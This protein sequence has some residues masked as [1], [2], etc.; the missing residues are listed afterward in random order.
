MVLK[1]RDLTKNIKTMTIRNFYRIA[2]L[3]IVSLFTGCNEWDE[4]NRTK[5]EELN[6]TLLEAISKQP[7]LSKF[8]EYLATTGYDV[9]LASSKTFTVWAPNNDALATLSSDITDDDQKLAQFIG[10]HISYQEYFKTSAP[11]RIKMVNGKNLTWY[12]TSL[13]DAAI[14]TA[15]HISRN[16]V[17][18][19]I[20]GI[21]PVKQN[22]WEV[23]NSIEAGQKQLSFLN[24]LTYDLF[25][26]S[27]AT[28]T[29]VDPATGLPIYEAGT[30]YVTKNYFF[31]GIYD[32]TNE[33]SLQTFFVLTDEAFDAELAKLAPF[34]KNVS[35]DQ[36]STDSLS[37][38]YLAKDLVVRGVIKPE[39]LPDTAISVDG[40]KI[41]ID[42]TAIVAHYETSNGMVYVMSKVDFRLKDK[43]PPIIIQGESPNAFSRTDKGTNI[44]IRYRDWANGGSDLRVYNHGIAQFNVRYR[45]RN[46]H[47]ATYKV[48]IKA[49]NDWIDTTFTGTDAHLSAFQQKVVLDSRETYVL[50]VP[51]P[52]ALKD[53]GYQKVNRL[54]PDLS[55]LRELYLGDYTH[56]NYKRLFVFVVA[57]NTANNQLNA[58]EVDYIKLVPVF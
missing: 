13:E 52:G 19:I 39:A 8:S 5:Q 28:Q 26:D 47:S 36:D 21:V 15:D 9:V 4:H 27:L 40:I 58:I 12:G 25:V 30:G 2:V 11:D 10:N 22:A 7:E 48:F 29:G 45:L 6:E 44:H 20:S 51:S 56:A 50:G 23:L 16:G 53:F 24:S 49:A 3:F 1:F 18:H 35:M 54:K 34:F 57:D 55:N 32:L 33:D 46:L 31:D 43:F 14:E 41:P 42:P 38:W 17:L 37:S